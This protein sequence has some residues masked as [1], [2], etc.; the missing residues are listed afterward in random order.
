ML[1]LVYLKGVGKGVLMRAMKA[2]R[3]CCG[4]VPLILNLGHRWR[5]VVRV[6]HW[7]LY[8]WGNRRWHWPRAGWMFQRRDLVSCHLVT[9]LTRRFQLCWY[10]NAFVYL[11][12][13]IIVL[14][15]YIW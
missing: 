1:A 14:L 2:Y 12:L 10:I 8:S 7:L 3:G 15:V 4:I 6:M 13:I 9:V 5:W 11:L